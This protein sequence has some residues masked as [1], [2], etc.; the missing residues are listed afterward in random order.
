MRLPDILSALTLN[1]ILALFSMIMAIFALGLLAFVLAKENQTARAESARFHPRDKIRRHESTV[2]DFSKPNTVPDHFLQ[3]N[4]LMFQKKPKNN[5]IKQMSVPISMEGM[6]KMNSEEDNFQNRALP[7]LPTEISR[8]QVEA[9]RRRV[10]RSESSS[11]EEQMTST[12]TIDSDNI[13]TE[14]S[15]IHTEDEWMEEKSTIEPIANK[16]IL[17]LECGSEVS[18]C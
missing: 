9:D 7:P 14:N 6:T 16:I 15:S 11:D 17:D 12:T 10:R 2:V 3:L 5:Q 13:S 1:A 4:T 18:L 8:N